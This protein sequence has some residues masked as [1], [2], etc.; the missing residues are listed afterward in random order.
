[1]CVCIYVHMCIYICVFVSQEKNYV[2]SHNK[3]SIL[4]K[5]ESICF[6]PK[7]FLRYR[8]SPYSNEKIY[9][10]L[11]TL[12]VA[13]GRNPHP[14]NW[15]FQKTISRQSLIKD[16]TWSP[17]CHLLALLPC[18]DKRSLDTRVLQWLQIL[19]PHKWSTAEK[20]WFHFPEACA[21]ICCLWLCHMF[22]PDQVTWEK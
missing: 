20:Q 7:T 22:E 18:S 4:A 11:K 17:F 19:Y 1:M 13:N 8:K 3:D 21:K 9:E 5:K 2:L 16:R 14:N 12:S 10:Y 6:L 15:F